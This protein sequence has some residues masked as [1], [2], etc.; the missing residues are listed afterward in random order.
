M[1][2]HYLILKEKIKTVAQ[3][4]LV[5]WYKQQDSPLN[6]GGITVVP[7]CYIEFMPVT[8]RNLGSD[9]KEADLNFNLIFITDNVLDNDFRIAPTEV[10][11]GYDHDALV[12][13]LVKKIE[14]KSGW[15]SELEAYAGLADSDD[16]RRYLGSMCLT[17]STPDHRNKALLKTIHSFTSYIKDWDYMPVYTPY[18]GEASL[19]IT[20]EITAPD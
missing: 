8:W 12:K 10:V 11:A 13:L 3:I 17:S 4:A 19:D 15:L 16:D 18:T 1:K 9:I 7:V 2:I 14:G 6:K 20:F 5:E